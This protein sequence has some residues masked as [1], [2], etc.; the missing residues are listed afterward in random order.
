MSEDA[1]KRA[2]HREEEL[3]AYLEGELPPE[4]VAELEA[5]LEGCEE[6]RRSLEGAEAVLGGLDEFL[7]L[8]AAPPPPI[9]AARLVVELDRKFP[10]RGRGRARRWLGLAIAGLLAAAAILWLATRRPAPPPPAP[11][12]PVPVEPLRP[13]RLSA[14]RRTPDAPWRDPPE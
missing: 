1:K 10:P 8:G 12:R 5:H 11:V 9:D 7:A 14:P 6:C 3:V 4:R 2:G 13:M